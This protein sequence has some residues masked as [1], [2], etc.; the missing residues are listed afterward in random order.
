MR[1][2]KKPKPNKMLLDL[3]FKTSTEWVDMTSFPSRDGGQWDQAIRLQ[4]LAVALQQRYVAGKDSIE[5]VLTASKKA[6]PGSIGAL[7]NHQIVMTNFLELYERASF[8]P[9]GSA[10]DKHLKPWIENMQKVGSE[11]LF[12]NSTTTAN[13]NEV[14]RTLLRNRRTTGVPL[15]SSVNWDQVCA[16]FRFLMSSGAK[17]VRSRPI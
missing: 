10:H 2:T 16:A 13:V 14:T 12:P 8:S 6:I 17:F 4:D 11:A 3:I 15:E 1:L 9:E 5:L 7:R